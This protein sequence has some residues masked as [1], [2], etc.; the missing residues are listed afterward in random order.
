MY[1]WNIWEVGI[2]NDFYMV[3][4]VSM[5]KSWYN[6]WYVSF[7]LVGFIIVDKFLVVFWFMVICVKI[8]GF[9]GWSIVLFLVLFG[10]GLVYLIYKMVKLIFG[11]LI[12]W[13]VVFFMIIILIVVVDFWIN[14]MDVMLVFFLLLVGWVL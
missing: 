4:I 13:I 1:G 6:F 7:D 9:Y 11:F 2:V 5:F 3:V 14:N 12:V 10:I 8:F